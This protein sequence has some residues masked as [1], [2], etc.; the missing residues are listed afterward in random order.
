MIYRNF[1]NNSK[2]KGKSITCIASATT[3]W[4]ARDVVLLIDR[5]N[6]SGQKAYQNS[7]SPA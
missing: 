5:R 1:E 3:I 7:T 2:A 4:L 6:C